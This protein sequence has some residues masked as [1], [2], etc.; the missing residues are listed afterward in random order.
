MKAKSYNKMEDNLKGC[1][2]VLA[3]V[4][5]LPGGYFLHLGKNILYFNMLDHSTVSSQ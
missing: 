3:D 5:F 4:I 2:Q 1:T